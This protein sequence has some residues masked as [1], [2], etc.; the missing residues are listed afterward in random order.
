MQPKTLTPSVKQAFSQAGITLTKEQEHVAASA[1]T[2]DWV[3]LLKTLGQIAVQVIPIIIAI[4]GSNT[5]PAPTPAP[6]PTPAQAQAGATCCDHH[7]CCCDTLKAIL[8][9]ADVC[10]KHMCQCCCG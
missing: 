4:F 9:S 10:S 7:K 2:V 5:P 1:T 6:S 3:S 8:H